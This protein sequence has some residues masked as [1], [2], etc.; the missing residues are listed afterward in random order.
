LQ[1]SNIVK[2]GITNEKSPSIPLRHQWIKPT[3]VATPTIG[4]TSAWMRGCLSNLKRALEIGNLALIAERRSELFQSIDEFNA[5][6]E[7]DSESS[8]ISQRW[9]VLVRDELQSAYAN[10]EIASSRL[11]S[12]MKLF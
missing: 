2:L 12:S 6:V 10:L 7:A 11:S 3:R 1:K 5:A 9:K 8:V 4:N